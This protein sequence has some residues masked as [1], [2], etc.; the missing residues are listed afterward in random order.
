MT[1]LAEEPE[2]WRHGYELMVETG[3]KSG[4]LYPI[5]MRMAERGLL[6]ATWEPNAPVGRPPRHLYRLTPA[7]H[8]WVR[9]ARRGRA[10]RATLRPGAA[11]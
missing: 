9:S 2:T 7:G 5:L 1:S 3:L 6:D 8:E 4:S 11:T 10:E